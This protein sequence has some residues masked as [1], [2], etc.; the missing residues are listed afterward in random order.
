MTIRK[1]LIAAIVAFPIFKSSAQW[2]QTSTPPG[3]G[4][5]GVNSTTF[6]VLAAGTGGSAG[7]YKSVN[8]NMG[9]LWIQTMSPAPNV[10][11]MA[12][13]TSNDYIY[14]GTQDGEVFKSTDVGVNWTDVTPVG[15]YN[16]I[17]GIALSD[18]HIYIATDGIGEILKSPLS[19]L[20]TNTWTS[21]STNL[22][23][24]LVRSIAVNGNKVYAGTYTQ[25]VWISPTSSANFD[26]ASGTAGAY[27]TSFAFNGNI[28]YAGQFFGSPSLYISTDTGNTWLPA[29][30]AG[31]NN[32]G[33]VSLLQAGPVIWAGTYGAGVFASVDSG[34]TWVAYNAGLGGM[35]YAIALHHYNDTLFA[36]TFGGVY[37]IGM[38]LGLPLPPPCTFAITTQPAATQSAPTGTNVQFNVSVNQ[39]NSLYRWQTNPNNV[40]WQNLPANAYYSGVTDSTL[41]VNNVQLSNHQQPFRAIVNGGLCD[42][43]TTTIS[44][45]VISDTCINYDT[46]Q[47]FDTI[48][49]Y[50]T[51]PVYDTIIVFD[52]IPYF[53]TIPVYDTIFVIDTIPYYDT[54]AVYDTIFVIDT[55]PYYDT[56]RIKVIDTIFVFDTVIVYDTVLVIDREIDVFMRHTGINNDEQAATVHIYPNPASDILYIDFGQ[57]DLMPGFSVSI[58]DV[59]G[60]IVYTA[61]IN[62]Q[63]MSINISSWANGTY[64]LSILDPVGNIV[65]MRKVVLQ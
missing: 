37:K 65:V 32:I 35:P 13:D 40:G 47:V 28:A 18:T 26:T 29:D 38:P 45:I 6:Y 51:I 59:T 34:D 19:S 52:T 23:N 15:S 1:I 41:Q 17:N 36:G 12:V 24:T 54:I 5:Y 25:G 50:D 16:P 30:T 49:Y 55:I 11:C 27:I 57:D 3:G 56:I 62:M 22:P 8:T 33:V 46:I 21:F 14:V 20:D 31:F 4:V 64:F 42:V 61:P 60:A 9:D 43:D 48:P 7:V 53:D 39:A 58:K 44:L 63:L 10:Q 2:V